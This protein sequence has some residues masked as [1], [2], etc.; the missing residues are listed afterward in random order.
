MRELSWPRASN[1]AVDKIRL[2]PHDPLLILDVDEGLAP[3]LRSAGYAV[4][5]ESPREERGRAVTW[6]QV[7]EI[8]VAATPV[9]LAVADRVKAWARGRKHGK[10][11]PLR[12][13]IYGPDGDVLSEFDVKPE[14]DGE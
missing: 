7:L 3:E 12:G 4:E 8:T 5:V 14:E 13:T 10:G 2:S 11:R 6:W 9:A 1:R